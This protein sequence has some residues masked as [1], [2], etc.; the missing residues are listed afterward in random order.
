M[1][2]IIAMVFREKFP[3][4][5]SYKA[6]LER[7]LIAAPFGIV[8]FAAVFVASRIGHVGEV[9]AIRETSVIF[10]ALIGYFIL[11]ERVTPLLFGLIALIACGAVLVEL[12]A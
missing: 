2:P 5:T 3:P 10:A 11:R 4:R 8:S 6:I 12:G 7:G 1:F 9:T